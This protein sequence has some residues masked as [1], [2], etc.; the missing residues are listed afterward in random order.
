M[1]FLVVAETAEDFDAWLDGQSQQAVQPGEGSEAAAGLEVF[2]TGGCIACHTIEGVEGATQTV[3]PTLT[4]FGSRRTLAGGILENTPDNVARWL[5]RPGDVK[6]GAKMR[7][8]GLTDEQIE[9]LVTY[10]RSL[11]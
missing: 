3:G 2:Q 11:E 5:N 9:D 6:T 10:L 4:H 8:Y 1:R 7:D